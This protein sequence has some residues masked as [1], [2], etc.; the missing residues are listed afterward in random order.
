MARQES[1]GESGKVSVLKSLQRFLQG[2]PGLVLKPIM[3]DSTG[4]GPGTYAVAPSG[5]GRIS[6]DILGNRVYQNNYVFYA[7]ES[8]D[9]EIDRQENYD[10]LD[11]FCDWLEEQNDRGNF[12]VFGDQYMVRNMSVSNT[13][14]YDVDED[15]TGIYQVQIQ[16]EL[17]RKR[18]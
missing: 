16:I 17:R 1:Q 18:R 9:C 8:A 5:N 2:C 4:E 12:P 11:A 10:F 7:K 3:T 14:L 13:M 15:G 6:T